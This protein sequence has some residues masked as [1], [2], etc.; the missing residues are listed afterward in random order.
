MTDKLWSWSEWK[1]FIVEI[2]HLAHTINY[3]DW[4]YNNIMIIM[5][6][7]VIWPHLQSFTYL[8][9]FLKVYDIINILLKIL[10]FIIDPFKYS[11]DSLK[12]VY[13]ILILFFKS[14]FIL[15]YITFYL[16]C[17]NFDYY[18]FKSRWMIIICTHFIISLRM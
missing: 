13:I 8:A 16:S 18:R 15:I 5:T 2:N 17:F 12:Y 11:L 9:I 3:L 6:I 14:W 10:L 4:F 1:R 7:I